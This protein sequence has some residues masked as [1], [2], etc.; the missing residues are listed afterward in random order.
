MNERYIFEALRS[1]CGKGLVAIKDFI[2]K[3][4]T[5]KIPNSYCI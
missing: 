1:P 3:R 5:F 2:R 4:D